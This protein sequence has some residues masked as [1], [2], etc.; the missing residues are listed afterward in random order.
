MTT[1]SVLIEMQARELA[2]HRRREFHK[3]I[4]AIRN[5]G[6]IERRRARAAIRQEIDALIEGPGAT[7]LIGAEAPRANNQAVAADHAPG[8][9]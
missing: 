6:T 5:T 8:K 2:E 3:T 1:S 7:D 4:R 9:K